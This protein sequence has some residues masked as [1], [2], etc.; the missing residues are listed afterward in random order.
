MSVLSRAARVDW[1]LCDRGYLL[2]LLDSVFLFCTGNWGVA[3]EQRAR[4]PHCLHNRL[5]E[6]FGR[7]TK[8]LSMYCWADFCLVCR[9]TRECLWRS[10]SRSKPST[11]N[12]KI[13]KGFL[14]TQSG[15]SQPKDEAKFIL[16]VVLSHV[17]TGVSAFMDPQELYWPWKIQTLAR[18]PFLNLYTV[19]WLLVEWEG[20]GGCHLLEAVWPWISVS[21]TGK[22][23]SPLIIALSGRE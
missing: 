22:I 12:A 20:G 5:G 21:L 9:E 14:R 18:S 10:E 2:C 19:L 15:V 7:K 11:G 17:C 6:S 16:C 3:E 8:R 1:C 13:K 4:Q 23:F